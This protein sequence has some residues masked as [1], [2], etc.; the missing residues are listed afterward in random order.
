MQ[1][2]VQVELD[3]GEINPDK[4]LNALVRWLWE[5]E[6]SSITIGRWFLSNEC[7]GLL[8]EQQAIDAC[9]VCQDFIAVLQLERLA[10]LMVS[11]ELMSR[12]MDQR[13]I[14]SSLNSSEIFSV[15]GCGM[16]PLVSENKGW[17]A[18]RN[19]PLMTHRDRNGVWSGSWTEPSFQTFSCRGGSSLFCG[20]S[21]LVTQ[22]WLK[23]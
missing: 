11:T 16:S 3:H 2:S 23:A 14:F 8:S 6:G 22:V 21:L 19:H 13:V 10:E 20:F 4:S 9:C 1:F 17:V 12:C 5:L 15:C 18:G 7:P